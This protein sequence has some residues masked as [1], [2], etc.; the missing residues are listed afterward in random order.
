[1]HR[2]LSPDE[3]YRLR[4]DRTNRVTRDRR[5]PHHVVRVVAAVD[6]VGTYAG[7]VQL[8]VAAN[9]L[10]RWCRRFELG[11]DDA[12]LHPLLQLPDCPTLHGRIAREVA[13]ADPFARFTFPPKPSPDVAYMLGI[14]PGDLAEP[15]H[16]RVH[17][18]EWHAWATSQRTPPAVPDTQS[19]VGPAFAAAL[20]IADAFK[21]ATGMP[22]KMRIAAAAFS[23][24][25][26]TLCPWD[27]PAAAP[28]EVG[29]P[30]LGRAQMVGVG[31]VGS[32]LVY[33]LRMLP[34][35]GEIPLIDHDAVG[36]ENLNR[37]P[38]FGVDDVGRPKVEVAAEYLRSALSVTPHAMTYGQY[39]DDRGRKPGDVDLLLPLANEFQVRGTIEHNFPPLQVYGTTT[40]DWGINFHRHVPLRDDCSVC[41]FPGDAPQPVLACSGG[42][43]QEPG[44]KPIDAALPF[45]SLAAAVL[46]L[47]DILRVREPGYP[48]TPN[49]SFIDFKGPLEQVVTFDKRLR[50]NCL[51][52]TRSQRIHRAYIDGTRFAGEA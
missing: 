12:P 44:A 51:C 15:T 18:D 45:L 35:S 21:V 24:Y 9:L 50:A 43:V 6:T 5:Y 36:Y 49:F 14:G 46:T 32:A 2:N 28:A 16:F 47:A 7:Q 1:M 23:L 42:Q 19:P 38:L 39:V 11:C 20:G 48:H 27:H 41:R 29:L 31:S 26:R 25:T 13:A 30:A 52:R 8:L 40:P 37:S 3:F 22:A 33:L 4:D 17:A 34:L 10:A